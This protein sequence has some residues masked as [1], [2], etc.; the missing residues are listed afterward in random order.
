MYH[1][2]GVGERAGTLQPFCRLGRYGDIQ[3]PPLQVSGEYRE[4]GDSR[5]DPPHRN[6]E[7]SS[8]EEVSSGFGLSPG[9][10]ILGDFLFT[11]ITIRIKTMSLPKLNPPITIETLRARGYAYR[12]ELESVGIEVESGPW[13]TTVDGNMWVRVDTDATTF[14]E[15]IE[16][17]WREDV[18]E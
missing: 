9:M 4:C 18:E 12:Y 13:V 5:R 2:N 17:E 3:E 8:Q 10:S 16:E 6:K 11:S 14:Y 7:G 1:Q 15:L